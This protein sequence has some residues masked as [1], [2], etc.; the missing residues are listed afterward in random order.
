MSHL[1]T[2]DCTLDGR[3]EVA[4]ARL[5]GDSWARSA[6]VSGGS[7]AA[8][9]AGWGTAIEVPGTGTLN[10]GGFASVQSVSCAGAGACAAG[11]SYKDGA[12]AYQAFVARGRVVPKP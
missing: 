12:G 11:G 9:A 1:L 10:S 5:A 4:G 6:T 3:P 7:A 8:I 2:E